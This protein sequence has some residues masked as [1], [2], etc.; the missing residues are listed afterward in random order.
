MTTSAD[1][2]LLLGYEALTAGAG[3]VDF[4]DRTLVELTGD[5]RAKFLHS[6]CTNDVVKLAAGTGCE[7]FLLNVQGKILAYVL[8]LAEREALVLETVGGQGGAIAKH[9]DRYLI[10]EKVAIR[11]RSQDWAEWFLAG[12]NSPAV[13]EKLGAGALPERAWTGGE[14]TI[15]GQ[16]VR[17][18]RVDIVG[19]TGFLIIGPRSSA[20]AIGEAI[21]AAGAPPV[22]P[23]A[24]AA[25]RIEAGFPLF[26]L[27]I[28]EKNL[29]QEIA[30]D[31]R[32]ISFNKGCYLGQETVARIDA[33][34]HVNR[35]LVGLR[36]T[37]DDVPPPAAALSAAGAEVGHITSAAFSPSANCDV[38]LAYVRR[39][40]HAPG[41]R[42]DWAGGTAEIVSLP[43]AK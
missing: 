24:F 15:A 25:A 16:A 10:R 17:L 5:D 12:P 13:L 28:T 23:A 9:L 37:G 39:G 40:H 35:L 18:W 34:G 22:A 26:G 32:T 6:F 3:L 11:D 8:I 41:T 20:P 33:L 29:P 19:P 43:A 38:A 4:S 1:S 27:D 36:L 14:T 30:R 42:L 7:A 21:V 2:Q 31:A